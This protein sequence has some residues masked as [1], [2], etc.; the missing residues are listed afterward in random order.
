MGEGSG[1]HRPP[2]QAF[3]RRLFEQSLEGS[4]EEK[5]QGRSARAEA[6]RQ[7]L[8][9]W[10]VGGSCVVGVQR[11]GGGRGEV[12]VGAGTRLG[13]RGAGGRL[14]AGVLDKGHLIQRYIEGCSARE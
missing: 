5:H 2:G 10:G 9:V 6:P 11:Q 8:G 14:R 12:T 7:E 1:H 3:Q 4:E 13:E